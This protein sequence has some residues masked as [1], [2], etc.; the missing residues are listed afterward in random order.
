M[1]MVMH[2][3][4]VAFAVFGCD[5]ED[6][7]DEDAVEDSIAPLSLTFLFKFYRSSSLSSNT[8]I[9]AGISRGAVGCRGC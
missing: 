7:D 8:N 1:S 4:A 9:C 2:V 6:R 3:A 5:G